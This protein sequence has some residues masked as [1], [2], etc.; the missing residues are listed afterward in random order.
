MIYTN[1]PIP[2]LVTMAT[3]STNDWE[4][5][6]IVQHGQLKPRASWIP[7]TSLLLNGKCHWTEYSVLR[8]P[9]RRA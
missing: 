3:E 5:P 9:K 8:T 4:D 6:K 1:Y 7:D 2:C